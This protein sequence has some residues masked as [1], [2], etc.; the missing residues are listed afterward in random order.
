M[1]RPKTVIEVAQP[2]VNAHA[3][4]SGRREPSSTTTP[5][6]PKGDAD[7]ANPRVTTTTAGLFALAITRLDLS[8]AEAPSTPRGTTE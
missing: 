3:F 4:A 7:I 5:R 6:I 8:W 1:T 2:M